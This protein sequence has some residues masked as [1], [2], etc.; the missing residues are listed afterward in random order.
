MIFY[1]FAMGILFGGALQD[2]Q[3]FGSGLREYY[4]GTLSVRK[5]LS[6]M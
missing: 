6:V 1:T 4:H 5:N 2:Y 3:M